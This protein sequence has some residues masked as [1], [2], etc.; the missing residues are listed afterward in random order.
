MKIGTKVILTRKGR[1]DRDL[2][3][4]TKSFSSLSKVRGSK[5]RVMSLKDISPIRFCKVHLVAPLHSFDL[6]LQG[7]LSRR[8][9]LSS[10]AEL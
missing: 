10:V 2:L 3:R 9:D 5:S 4:N 1:C 8:P 6:C 7:N